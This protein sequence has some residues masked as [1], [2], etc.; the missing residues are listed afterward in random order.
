MQVKGLIEEDEKKTAEGKESD[1]TQ[2]EE[3][4]EEESDDTTEE[5]SDEEEEEEEESDIS[6]QYFTDPDSLPKELRGAFKKMQGIYTRK[7]QEASLGIKKSRAFDQL[8]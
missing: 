3:S 1:E 7:M 4:S 8:V 5:S 2:E 6:K